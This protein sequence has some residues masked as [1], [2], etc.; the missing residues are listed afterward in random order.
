M[1][2]LLVLVALL[3]LPGAALRRAF[4]LAPGPWGTGRLAV[5]ASLSLALLTVALLPLYATSA[6]LRLAPPMAFAVTALAVLAALRPRTTAR[7]SG[8]L[9]GAG[10]AEV[11]AFVFALAV[12]LPTTLRHAGANVDDWWDLS[13]VRGWMAQGHFDFAQM[14]LAAET[15]VEPG[16]HPR[17]LWN[18]WLVLQAVVATATGAEPWRTQAGPLAAL[19]MTLVVSAQAALA[20]VIFAKAAEPGKAVA[21]TVAL[22]AAWIWGSEALPLFVRGYQDKLFAGFVLAPVLIA[23]MVRAADEDPA[24]TRRE[25]GLSTASVAAAAVAAVSVHS[26]VYTMAVACGVVAVAAMRG[27]ESVRWA[28]DRP[29]LLAALALPGLYPLGQAL[30]LAATFGDQGITLSTPDNPVVRAHLTLGRLIGEGGPWW[31]VHPGAV[32]GPIALFALV[33]LAFAWRH[34]REERWARLLLALALFPALLLFVPGLAAAAGRLWVPWMLYRLGWMVP[35]APLLALALLGLADRRWLAEDGREQGDGDR[36]R[37]R[38]WPS[39]V[40]AML[41][42]IVAF[43]AGGDRLRRD[44]TEHPAPPPSSPRGAAAVV[45]RY[46]AGQQGRGA[47]LAPPNFSELLPALAGKPV[48]AFP[49]RGT[50]VFA[51]DEAAAYERMRARAAFYSAWTS[52]GERDEVADRYAVRWAVLPRRL[53][54]SGSEAAWMRRYGVEATTAARRVD[55]RCA[56]AGNTAA[57]GDL[58]AVDAAV[59]GACAGWW[60]PTEERA[61]AVLGPR[62]RIVLETRDYFVAEREA[63]DTS[64]A[65]RNTGAASVDPGV[66][67]SQIAAAGIV[68]DAGSSTAKDDATRRDWRRPFGLGRNERPASTPEGRRRVLG[69]LVGAPAVTAGYDVPPRFVWPVPTPIWIEGPS[70]WE[71]SPAEVTVTLDLGVACRVD[72]VRLLPHLPRSRREV[73]EADVFG[74]LHRAEARHDLAWRID[75]AGDAARRRWTLRLRSLLGNPVSLGDVML[76]GDPASCEGAWPAQG[77]PRTPQLSPSSAELL[78]AAAVNAESG[79]P[80]VSLARRAL[81]DGRA[82][83]SRALFA[84]ATRREPSLVEAWIERGFA[85]DAAGDAEAARRAFDGALEADSRSGWAHGAKAWAE[86]R[87][88]NPLVAIHHALRAASLDPL[89]ADAWTILGITLGDLHLDPLSWRAFDVAER[90]DRDRNWPVLARAELLARRGDT[91]A[92]IAALRDRLERDPFDV[93]VRSSLDDLVAAAAPGETAAP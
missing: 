20:R 86:R 77:E 68:A 47:V 67:D 92:A 38:R 82:G 7:G 51:M 48:V 2:V 64:I 31:V 9:D 50:L 56:A 1:T 11:T 28:L 46:L 6:P 89:Y 69:R 27:R 84:A 43:D 21:A 74:R 90:K 62:W 37:V 73:L 15:G 66:A 22:T 91:T 18:V 75:T 78:R 55:E 81:R 10:R 34:R 14:A 88:G 83:A 87:N 4:A 72:E 26:L 57:Q 19:A 76:V 29:G 93:E 42:A 53:V 39:V 80:L 3:W 58:A 44:M 52:P 12:L 60:S 85:D 32:F 8:P 71:D 65:V 45:V 70:P 35:V 25:R 54:A 13:F 40:F 41:V 33:G 79:R 23:V 5:E 61:I 49:E 59:D 24:H 16:A 17:F 30:V 63:P 36:V